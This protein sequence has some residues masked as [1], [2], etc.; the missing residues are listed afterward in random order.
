MSL[1]RK[2]AVSGSLTAPNSTTA[3]IAELVGSTTIRPLVYDIVVGSSATPA[4]NAARFQIQRATTTGSGATTTLTPQALDGGDPA[5]TAVAYQGTW[6][7]TQ[8][9]L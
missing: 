5:A 1:G 3:P 6:T 2:Y 8:P 4:D 7:T 9:T